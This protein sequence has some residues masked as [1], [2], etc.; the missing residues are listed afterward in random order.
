[1][2]IKTLIHH[3]AP[4]LAGLKV[5]NLFC[6]QGE[7]AELE[8]VREVLNSR[9]IHL[10]LLK[11]CKDKLIYVYRRT[12]L[13]QIL[14]IEE[15]QAFLRNYGHHRFNIEELLDSSEEKMKTDAFP[16]EIGILLGYPLEDVKGF[17]QHRGE[18]SLC[19]GHWKVYGNKEQAQQEFSLF[20][21]CTATYVEWY[22]QGKPLEHL[23]LSF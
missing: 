7:L 12:W 21:R 14:A 16:H 10:R 6:Y 13:E 8:Q 1:M 19:C 23:A 22:Q 17:I 11:E 4:T 20:H 15:N 2:L 9:G 18:K 3:G 5:A